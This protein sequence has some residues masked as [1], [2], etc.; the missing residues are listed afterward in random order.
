MQSSCRVH[1]R[2]RR[3]CREVSEGSD[4]DR[5]KALGDSTSAW[6]RL[7]NGVQGVYNTWGG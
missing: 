1:A 2:L 5:I 7:V 3:A 4:G 6:L